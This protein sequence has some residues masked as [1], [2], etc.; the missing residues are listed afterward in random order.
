MNP[1][2]FVIV[3]GNSIHHNKHDGIHVV[4]SNNITIND[5]CINNNGPGACTVSQTIQGPI[6]YKIQQTGGQGIYMDPSNNITIDHNVISDNSEY[7]VYIDDGKNNTI[8][9]NDFIDNHGGTNQSKDQ[10]NDTIYKNSFSNNH[11]SDYTGDGTDPY[12]IDGSANNTD[13]SP[14]NISILTKTCP[15]TPTPLPPSPTTT[16]APTDGFSFNVIMLVLLT[17]TLIVRINPRFRKKN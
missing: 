10:N 2:K 12:Y 5:N 17:I 9:S 4:N 7:G 14:S 16:G 8:T 1:S 11:W 15:T 6:S 3:S 13:S